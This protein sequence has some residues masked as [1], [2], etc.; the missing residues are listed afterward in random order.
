MIRIDDYQPARQQMQANS[1]CGRPPLIERTRN[2]Y[3]K[4]KLQWIGTPAIAVA[5]MK[6][7]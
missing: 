3:Q 5:D 6:P 4:G 2:T 1:S 7:T